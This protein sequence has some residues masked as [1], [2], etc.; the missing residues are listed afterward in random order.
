LSE[1]GKKLIAEL[2]DELDQ[3]DLTETQKAKAKWTQLE[4][5]IGSENRIKQIA[6]DI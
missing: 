5:L 3:G 1:E 4:A 6:R 2:D